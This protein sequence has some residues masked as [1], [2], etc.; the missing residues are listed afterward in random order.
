MTEAI[1][2]IFPARYLVFSLC[3][4]GL[5]L[6]LFSLLAFG[7]GIPMLL[8]TGFLVAVGVYDL[9]QTKRS[10]PVSYTHLTLPTKRIV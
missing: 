10:I 6:S 4:L 2:K 7:V 3:C 8:L 1:N 5:L 9:R